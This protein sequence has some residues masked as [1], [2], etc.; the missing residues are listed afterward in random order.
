MHAETEISVLR[1]G[2][3]NHDKFVDPLPK[4]LCPGAT[5]GTL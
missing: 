2:Q 3:F 5:S 4:W 1:Q